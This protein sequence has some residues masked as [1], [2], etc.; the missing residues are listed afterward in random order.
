[1]KPFISTTFY[2][3][4]NYIV[5]ILLIA[6]PWIFDF[7]QYGGAPLFMPILIGWLQL[8][9]AIFSRNP[10]GIIN[11]FPMQMHNCLDVLTG[12]F[13]LALPWTYDFAGKVWAPHFVFGLI[14]TI[15]GIFVSKSPFLTRPDRS[16]PEAGLTSIDSLE[17]RLDH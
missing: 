10:V 12:T 16:L 4:A 14:L 1:M 13:L 3:V 8:I 17:G 6:S 9:M 2:G 7:A 15:M 11:I 5:A